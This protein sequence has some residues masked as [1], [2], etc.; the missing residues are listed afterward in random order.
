MEEEKVQQD[1]TNKS[2]EV[3]VEGDVIHLP[4]GRNVTVAPDKTKKILSYIVM[5][6]LTIMS[7]MLRGISS[8]SFVSP[9]N[10]AV[11]GIT[12][13]AVMLQYGTGIN[14]GLF[15]V[16]L[17]IPLIV[18]AFIFLK[19]K[20]S[21]LTLLFIVCNALTT[22]VIE[23]IGGGEKFIYREEQTAIISAVF[24][25]VM[26]GVSLVIMLRIGGAQGGTDI[27]ASI[28]QKKRPDIGISWLIFALDSAVV[29]ASF[30]VYDN[31]LTPILLSIVQSFSASMMSETLLKGSKSALKVEI[32]T[33]Y[34]DEISAEIFAKIGRG[35]T[36]TSVVGMYTGEGHKLLVTVI[37]RRQLGELERII[38]KY[39]D[40]FSYIVPANEV[41]GFWKK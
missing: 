14:Q 17:N 23:L 24:S 21:F 18:L 20:F 31:G 15:I 40:T 22:Y 5:V 29:V 3:R 28:M 11:G 34:S 39:P 10:F 25:G 8:Y 26:F 41:L 2:S 4:G 37:K 12:G 30:F 27:I 1:K 35:V 6:L 36:V 33:D 16:L 38:K 13:I 9:N 7:A 19:K 32:V